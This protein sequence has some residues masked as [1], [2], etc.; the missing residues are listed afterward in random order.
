MDR[1]W[2]SGGGGTKIP[3]LIEESVFSVF[4][5]VAL[6]EVPGIVVEYYAPLFK[7]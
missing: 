4:V 1:P 2:L 6:S 5:D 3:L 7:S